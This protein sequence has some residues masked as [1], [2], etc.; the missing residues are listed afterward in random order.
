[1]LSLRFLCICLWCSFPLLKIL[2]GL[3]LSILEIQ[4]LTLYSLL[5]LTSLL[6]IDLLTLSS[7][8]EKLSVPIV[9]LELK[10]MDTFLKQ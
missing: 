3:W 5:L 1:M 8:L 7:M 6:S 2:Q 10:E 9:E 4:T